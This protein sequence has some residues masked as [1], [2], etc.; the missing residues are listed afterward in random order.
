MQAIFI[1]SLK[2]CY[3]LC[4]RLVRYCSR[5]L[6]FHF[7]VVSKLCFDCSILALTYAF[8][9]DLSCRSLNQ[10]FSCGNMECYETSVRKVLISLCLD[11]AFLEARFILK[12][13]N[14]QSN[15][16]FISFQASL[17]VSSG[18]KMVCMTAK[19]G[20]CLPNHEDTL[21]SCLLFPLQWEYFVF[22]S[23]YCSF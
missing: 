10:E 1:L 11:K 5:K 6:D 8:R 17:P 22:L 4:Y 3:L 23:I 14:F 12:C 7:P 21:K 18:F 2:L 15:G 9:C 16:V 20:F 13:C 19:F